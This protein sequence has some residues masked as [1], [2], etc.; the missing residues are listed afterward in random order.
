MKSWDPVS[1]SKN[2][3][4]LIKRTSS[5]IATILQDLSDLSEGDRRS[6]KDAER[7][8]RDLGA[9]AGRR[10][11]QIKTNE[12][13]LER[14]ETTAAN[15]ARESLAG[16]FLDDTEGKIAIILAACGLSWG[17]SGLEDDLKGYVTFEGVKIEPKLRDLVS[18]VREAKESIIREVA[19][20]AVRAK[21][22]VP[23]L[24]QMAEAKPKFDQL[25]ISADVKDLTLRWN[26]ALVREQLENANR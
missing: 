5:S 17:R 6:L 4:A 3:A 20:R 13:R 26:A 16:W 15:Q 1:R 19:Y 8:L 9:Q 22:T 14:L 11:K 10:A 23:V 21:N 12:E 2:Q 25:K 18:R 7:I 24:E